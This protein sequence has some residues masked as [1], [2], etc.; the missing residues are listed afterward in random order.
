MGTWTLEGD[1]A[2]SLVAKALESG[3]RH[4]D[5]AAMYKNENEV[6][7]GL[8][9]SG[10]ARDDFFLTTKVWPSEA[11]PEDFIASAEASL[12]RLGTDHVD[13]ILIH[14]PSKTVPFAETI[15]AL[16]EVHAKGWAKAIGISNFKPIPRHTTIKTNWI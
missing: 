6:G 1:Q 14:W 15:A 12:D 7:Q 4:I 10:L 5:T 3:Y 8:K 16:N 2:R 11:A 13:L 9:D